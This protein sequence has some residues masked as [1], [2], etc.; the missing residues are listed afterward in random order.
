VAHVGFVTGKDLVLAAM[1]AVA[2]LAAGLAQ[3]SAGHSVLRQAGLYEEPASYTSLAF[4]DPQSLPAYLSPVP[5]QVSVP[6]VVTNTS[7][8]P[9][10]YHWSIALERAGR[11]EDLAAGE[12]QV[13]AEDSAT[14]TTTVGAEC[15]EGQARM[16]VQIGAPA[17]S[18]DFWLACGPQGAKGQPG[19]TAQTDALL[20][21]VPPGGRQ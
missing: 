9:R 6:F 19:A 13:Q 11:T 15:A 8:R 14:V 10:S 1:V 2:A 3:T 18:V 16:T 12:V 20:A 5:T 21:C 7:E 4:A 17:E